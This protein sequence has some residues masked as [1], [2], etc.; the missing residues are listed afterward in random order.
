MPIAILGHWICFPGALTP[1]KVPLH[2]LGRVPTPFFIGAN[3]PQ[4]LQVDVCSG[5][6]AENLTITSCDFESVDIEM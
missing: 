5:L 4:G 1:A 3:K 2:G 6:R